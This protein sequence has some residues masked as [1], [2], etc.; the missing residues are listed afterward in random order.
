MPQESLRGYQFFTRKYRLGLSLF[1]P[2]G[3]QKDIA[4]GVSVGIR[5]VDLYEEAVKLGLWQRIGALLFN[6]VLRREHVEGRVQGA[7]FARDRHF[8]LLHRLQQ[9]RLRPGACAVDFIRHQKLTKDR[10]RHEFKRFGAVLAGLKHFGPQNIRGHQIRRELHAIAVQPHHGGQ[11][12]HQSCFTQ[13]RQTDQQGMTT[14]QQRG[15]SE[16]N[17]L[18]LSDETPRDDGFRLPEPFAQR[19]DV[20]QHFLGVGHDKS[21]EKQLST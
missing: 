17:D 16:I 20:A 12:V 18:L 9:S 3:G 8:A 15:Q 6:R 2:C 5:H 1:G 13:A 10:T 14:T 7:I 11:R 19:L 4:F 21:P